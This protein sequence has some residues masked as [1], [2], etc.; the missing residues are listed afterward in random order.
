VR[1]TFARAELELNEK[2]LYERLGG[3]PAVE[4][5]VD[6]FYRK[7]LGDELIS[8]HFEDV[9]MARQREKQ[10]AFLSFAF[11]GPAYGTGPGL[12][13]VHAR[14]KLTEPDFDAV[15]GHLGATLVEL[16]VPAELIKEAARIALSVKDDVLNR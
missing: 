6:V 2:S 16:K 1:R 7:V 13:A 3:E 12:R 5:A 14:L 4:A 11:G 15:M 10:K 8:H 9:D